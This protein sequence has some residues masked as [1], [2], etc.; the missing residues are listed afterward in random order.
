M[1]AVVIFRLEEQVGEHEM[2]VN[3][4]VV[5]FGKL[6]QLKLAACVVPDIR[7]KLAVVVVEF[8]CETF[9]EDG[10]RETE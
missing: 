9:A 8:P 7:V 2:G 1:T 4:Q 10:D 5:S 3:V 6:E